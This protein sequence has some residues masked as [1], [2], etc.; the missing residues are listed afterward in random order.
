VAAEHLP[1][2]LLDDIERFHWDEATFKVDWSLD[3]P[4][5]WT[6]PGARQAGTVHVTEGVDALTVTSGEL[7]RGLLPTDP[8]L[9]V[10]Q[11]SMTDPTRQPAGKETAWAYT[12]LP[13]E[14]RGDARGELTGDWEGGD[15]ERYADR[16]EEGIEAL[17]PGFR[18]LIRGRHLLTPNSFEAENPNLSLGAIGGGTSQLHQQLVFRPTPGSGR[19]STP[20]ER[21]FL[22]SSSAHPGGGLHGAPGRIAA[23]AAL[24]AD[25]RPW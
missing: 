3:G 11:Q 22:A 1:S 4:I 6:A 18:S 13:R 12:H 17:A 10:G 8:F 25:R 23:R 9:L 20:V 16:I 24:A 15:A 19:A 5:P 14:V 7:V 21:L 2:S